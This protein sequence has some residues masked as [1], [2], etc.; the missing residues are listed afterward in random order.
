MDFMAD[1]EESTYCTTQHGSKVVVQILVIYVV[2]SQIC[3]RPNTLF[4]SLMTPKNH[5]MTK[6]PKDHCHEGRV[7]KLI[8]NI[9][10]SCD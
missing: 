8:S 5:K 4:Q 1:Y 7:R 3:F 10:P 6:N 2:A 9:G